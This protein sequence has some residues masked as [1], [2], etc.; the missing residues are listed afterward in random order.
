VPKGERA[1]GVGA[2][3]LRGRAAC[4]RRRKKISFE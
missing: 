2:P 4:K 3:S 1:P